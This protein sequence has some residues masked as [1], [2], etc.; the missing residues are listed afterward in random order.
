MSYVYVSMTHT[1]W[2]PTASGVR[3]VLLIYHRIPSLES[4]MGSLVGG[5]AYNEQKS[6]IKGANKLIH[7]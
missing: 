3:L 5:N 1:F 2:R 4:K 7:V 6:A